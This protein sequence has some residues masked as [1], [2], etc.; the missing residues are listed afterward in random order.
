MST[1]SETMFTATIQRS[2]PL[3]NARS[4]CAA[5]ASVWTTTTGDLPVISLSVAATRRAWP[6]SAVMTSPPASR[7]PPA[8]TSSSLLVR[9][10][11]DPRQPVGELRRDRGAVA[12]AGLAR[13]Q[14]VVEGGLDDVV[15]GLP[16]QRPVVGD[17]RDR[18]ADAVA[19]GLG[20]AVADVRHGD[21]A[22]VAHARDRGLVGAKRRPRQ[23]QPAIGGRE[24][25]REALAPRELVAHV[26]ALVGD[27]ERALAALR[28]PALRRLRD[29]RVRRDDAV[30]V[31]RR[32][33]LV[34][35]GREL[36]AEAPGGLGPLA[37]QRRRR[38][39][40]VNALDDARPQQR[41][42]VHERRDRLARAGR[43][44][45]QERALV[46][47]GH[48]LQGGRLPRPEGQR[49]ARQGL[50]RR[51]SRAAQCGLR[52]GRTDVGDRPRSRRASAGPAAPHLTIVDTGGFAP[53]RAP[54]ARPI[55]PAWPMSVTN[56]RVWTTWSRRAPACS[57]ALSIASRIASTWTAA[58]PWPS[59]TPSSVTAVVPATSTRSPQRTARE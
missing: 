1:P 55:S 17:E 2:R 38:A 31:A 48:L 43:G 42:G 27:D 52:A 58:S 5:R 30:E 46:P 6:L 8:R 29:A 44:G 14:D 28:R 33:Q 3:P 22:V 59:T 18:P 49:G 45:Q 9:G 24:R 36:D 20:V 57:S 32:R 53:K 51:R 56:M 10:V 34:G 4:F 12:A 47:V 50:S 40:D 15:A 16:R 26:V 13:R 7:W 39:D 21:A 11:Q 25:A 37:R 23:Q 41:P 54:W 19:H 35:V